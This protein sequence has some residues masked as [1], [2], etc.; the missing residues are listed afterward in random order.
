MTKDVEEGKHFSKTSIR[1]LNNIINNE[2]FL[3]IN[4]TL[5]GEELKNMLLKIKTNLSERIFSV[6]VSKKE[7]KTIEPLLN[8]I[9]KDLKNDK[10]SNENFINDLIIKK[11][12]DQIL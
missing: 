10:K 5:R 11:R 4:T 3:R 1:F 7:S 2:N 8:Q 9:Y 6:D 12:K